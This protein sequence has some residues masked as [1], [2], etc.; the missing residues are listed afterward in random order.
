MDTALEFFHSLLRWAVLLALVVAA[1]AAWR[2]YFTKG[3]IIVLERLITIVAMVLCHVQLVIGA[4]LYGL[5]FS[6]FNDR[7]E[8]TPDLMRFWKMEHISGMILAIVLVT[9][10]RVLSK[11]ARSEAGKQLRVAIFYTLGLLII[12]AMIPWPFMAKFAHAYG[13]L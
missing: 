10:G 11:K 8:A 9:M 3:P 6:T 4:A 13:W 12:L 5:R 1:G 2:G 7:F